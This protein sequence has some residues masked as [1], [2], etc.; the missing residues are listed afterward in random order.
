MWEIFFRAVPYEHIKSTTGGFW[1]LHGY[2]ENGGRPEIR[3][4][5]IAADDP[6]VALMRACWDDDPQHRPRADEI[7]SVLASIQ[8]PLWEG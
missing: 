1:E 4:A 2:I 7:V 8:E 6:Y 5:H 3:G